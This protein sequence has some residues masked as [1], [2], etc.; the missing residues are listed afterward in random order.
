MNWIRQSTRLA[1]YLRDGM[2]CGYCGHSVEDGA[3]LT[4][5]HLRTYSA[6]GSNK[7]ANLVT[8]CSRCNRSRGTRPVA[9]FAR[10][11]AEYL[12][13]GITAAEITSHVRACTRRALPRDEAN[14]LIRRRGSVAKVLRDR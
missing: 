5:D 1:I 8:C 10:A 11:V 7:P 14:E 3:E 4:L 12:D 6:G 9:A 2:S 13:H